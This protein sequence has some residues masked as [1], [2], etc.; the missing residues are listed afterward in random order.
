MGLLY[1]LSLPPMPII[2]RPAT[3]YPSP[4]QF[5]YIEFTAR[6]DDMKDREGWHAAVCGVAK[7]GTRLSD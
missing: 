7:S 4:Q 3:F 6:Y 2:L 5:K 1:L